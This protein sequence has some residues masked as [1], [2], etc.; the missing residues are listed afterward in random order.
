M[1]LNIYNI[2]SKIPKANR[3]KKRIQLKVLPFTEGKWL[4]AKHIMTTLMTFMLSSS[5]D[6]EIRPGT[7]EPLPAVTFSTETGLGTDRWL[8]WWRSTLL[9]EEG[10]RYRRLLLSVG[11]YQSREIQLLR[12]VMGVE[13]LHLDVCGHIEGTVVRRRGSIGSYDV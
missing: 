1:V 9:L 10:M 6:E 4:A 12:S 8:E 11:M 2:K 5:E 7:V 13:N 3:K